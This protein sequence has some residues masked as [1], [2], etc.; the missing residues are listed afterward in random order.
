MTSDCLPHQVRVPRSYQGQGSIRLPLALLRRLSLDEAEA[1]RC[2]ERRL[3]AEACKRAAREAASV[4]EA[5]EKR[6]VNR[7]LCEGMRL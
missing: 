4:E 6:T 7:L 2:L 1:E 5:K 3:E